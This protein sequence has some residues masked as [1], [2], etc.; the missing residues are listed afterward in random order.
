MIKKNEPHSTNG[1]LSNLDESDYARIIRKSELVEINFGDRLVTGGEP[2]RHVHFPQTGFVSLVIDRDD[3]RSVEVGIYGSEG[4]G[5]LA[6]ALEAERSATT[7]LVQYKGEAFRISADDFANFLNDTP[8]FRRLVLRYAQIKM[9]QLMQTAVSVG[10]D[11]V[12]RRLARWLLMCHDRVP[13][14]VLEIT[15]HYLSVI[16]G[17]RRSGVTDAMHELEGMQLV[18]SQR[19]RVTIV[20]RQ[21]LEALAGASYGLPE[22][23]YAR[24]IGQPGATVA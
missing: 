21:R 4:M 19:G 1:L 2:P 24:L 12:E 22:K 23:E 17:V 9:M 8:N 15:H 7:E 14:N 16:L 3:G 20:D 13:G 5:S 10:Y 11:R 18:R 6:L